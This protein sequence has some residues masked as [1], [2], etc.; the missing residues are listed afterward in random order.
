MSESRLA[1]PLTEESINLSL[2]M[3][4]REGALCTMDEF[5]ELFGALFKRWSMLDKEERRKILS[6]RAPTI[7]VRGGR[8]VS[9][10]RL[11]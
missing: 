10:F 7:R 11:A 8:V 4:D 2:K 5:Y 3:A 9:L 1:Q 6:L